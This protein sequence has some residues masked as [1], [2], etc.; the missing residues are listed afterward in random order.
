[1]NEK[2]R[3]FLEQPSAAKIF[4][5]LRGMQTEA[6]AKNQESFAISMMDLSKSLN[7]HRNTISGCIKKMLELEILTKN[8]GL[9]SLNQ[10]DRSISHQS[11][12]TPNKVHKVAEKESEEGG[13]IVHNCASSCTELHTDAQDCNVMQ[14]DADSEEEDLTENTNAK[15]IRKSEQSNPLPSNFLDKFNRTLITVRKLCTRR[16]F[17]DKFK[18]A[19]E[20]L[21]GIKRTEELAM[22]VWER[23]ELFTEDT[24]KEMYGIVLD[25]F[26]AV[27]C[28]GQGGEYEGMTD[29]ERLIAGEYNPE[30][31]E[32]TFKQ[33]LAKAKANPNSRLFGRTYNDDDEDVDDTVYDFMEDNVDETDADDEEQPEDEP[34]PEPQPK[35]KIV[36]HD[37]HRFV[38]FTPDEIEEILED[39]E[40]LKSQFSPLKTFIYYVWMDLE[41]HYYYEYER[42]AE[43]D[44]KKGKKTPEQIKEMLSNFKLTKNAMVAPDVLESTMKACY[45]EILAIWEENGV[46]TYGSDENGDAYEQEVFWDDIDLFDFSEAKYIFKWEKVSNPDGGWDYKP[47]TRG[48]FNLEAKPI[49][50]PSRVPRSLSDPVYQEYMRENMAYITKLLAADEDELNDLERIIVRFINRYYTTKDHPKYEGLKLIMPPRDG[51]VDG[52][53]LLDP[54]GGYLHH[55]GLNK[56]YRLLGDIGVSPEDFQMCLQNPSGD[57]SF[58]SYLKVQ[59]DMFWARGIA[60][61]CAQKGLESRFALSDV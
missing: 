19:L 6:I 50:K 55:D 26:S 56:L 28:D 8:F 3:K 5:A 47:S 1:M 38:E 31:Q 61:I 49:K 42:K 52:E 44:R 53:Q 41:D 2:I 43:A 12:S 24:D 7:I 10:I 16:R 60:Y 54:N 34:E 45:S 39:K 25:L 15:Q 11:Q 51:I 33:A 23:E 32:V 17:N 59:R 22:F 27:I 46:A 14:D 13:R 20:R 35:H 48:I 37:S 40:G 36:R 29:V 21:D 58:H 30:N 57:N 9:Y 4:Q 18:H